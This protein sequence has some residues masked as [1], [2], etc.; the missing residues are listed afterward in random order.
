MYC[1]KRVKMYDHKSC[2]S[3]QMSHLMTK[4]TK[5]LCTQQRLRSAWHP[6]SL[7]WVF[8]V[9]MKKAW[10]LSYPL[11]AQRRLWSNW[12]D[13]QADLS[14]HWEHSYFVGFVML[15]LKS[16]NFWTMQ[17]WYATAFI[18]LA[19][20]QCELYLISDEYCVENS[21]SLS[22]I[23]TAEFIHFQIILV[24]KQYKHNMII[25]IMLILNV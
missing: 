11:S 7:I 18:Y 14:L 13:A 2:H 16:K 8:A 21:W 6:P 5:W 10:I 22:F 15:R 1:K 19:H 9:G 25:L 3:I 23:S 4:P 12:A 24:P 20:L 17:N